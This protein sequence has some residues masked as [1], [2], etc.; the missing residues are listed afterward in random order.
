M[1]PQF[2]NIGDSQVALSSAAYLFC[3]LPIGTAAYFLIP[4][5]RGKNIFLIIFGLIFYAFGQIEGVILL[6][7]SSAVNYAAGVLI[8]R[9]WREKTEFIDAEVIDLLMLFDFK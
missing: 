9:G 8:A 6:L 4:N 3:F 7:L 1:K 5:L 2:G